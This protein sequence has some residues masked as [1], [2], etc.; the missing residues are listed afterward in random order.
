MQRNPDFQ[1]AN[2]RRNSPVALMRSHLLAKVAR[3]GERK[4]LGGR[5]KSLP[6]ALGK[7]WRAPQ[8]GAVPVAI[9]LGV[10]M[11]LAGEGQLA[12]DAERRRPAWCRTPIRYII[13]AYESCGT[14]YGAAAKAGSPA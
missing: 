9:A 4:G 6:F 3:D 8:R 14:A 10:G 2:P 13:M 12:A 1:L 5:P 7:L 11:L